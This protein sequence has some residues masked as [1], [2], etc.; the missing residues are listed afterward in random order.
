MKDFLSSSDSDEVEIMMSRN[1]REVEDDGIGAAIGVQ[2]CD[3]NV[4]HV[5]N[6]RDEVNVE[7]GVDIENGVNV[8]DRAVEDRVNVEDEDNV[9]D[10]D[11]VNT[12]SSLSS[13]LFEPFVGKE[14]DEVED[15]QAFY[16][17]YAR[18]KCFA[19]RTNNT[20]LSKE[21]R[22]LI[23]VE[24]VCSKEG[25]RHESQ[26]PKKKIPNLMRQRLS[27]KQQCV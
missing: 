10:E 11:V 17:A 5:P 1:Y 8:E 18:R 19:M 9:G 22:K 20:R 7:E 16:K 27:V 26:K 13:D 12:I 4:L 14:F 3:M 23:L 15:A 25:F 24:Y 2:Q 21:D 6:V